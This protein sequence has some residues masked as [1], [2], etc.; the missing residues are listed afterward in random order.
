MT[1]ICPRPPQEIYLEDSSLQD[2]K[3]SCLRIHLSPAPKRDRERVRNVSK[4]LSRNCRDTQRRHQ[5]PPDI[6]QD[7]YRRLVFFLFPIRNPPNPNSTHFIQIARPHSLHNA[8]TDPVNP[9]PAILQHTHTPI[10]T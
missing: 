6:I 10:H 3:G 5:I 4:R 9:S 7:N 8:P 1:T 2:L